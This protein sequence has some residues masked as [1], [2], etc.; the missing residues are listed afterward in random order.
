MLGLPQASSNNSIGTSR[1]FY[2][3]S[4]T[5]CADSCLGFVLGPVNHCSYV[6]PSAMREPSPQHCEANGSTFL[7]VH[8][9]ESMSGSV[10]VA[11]F[12]DQELET[13]AVRSV[14]AAHRFAGSS[15]YQHPAEEPTRRVGWNA[16][17]SHLQN[18]PGSGNVSSLKPPRSANSLRSCQAQWQRCSFCPQTGC[19]RRRRHQRV[20]SR[21]RYQ[22]P[23]RMLREGPIRWCSCLG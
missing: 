15:L 4:L 2:H 1:R 20:P 7:S 11:C 12:G 16:L 19:G 14:C 6:L 21:H 23:T 8:S 9:S 18:I 3:I 5:L 22:K 10:S 13:S 17:A